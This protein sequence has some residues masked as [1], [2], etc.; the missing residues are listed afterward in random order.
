[1][2][3]KTLRTVALLAISF[4]SVVILLWSN[5][6]LFFIKGV[7]NGGFQRVKSSG[8]LQL[9]N[10]YIID[11][12]EYRIISYKK[13][14][15]LIRDLNEGSL[16]QI[17]G[18]K[19]M[20]RI[21]LNSLFDPSSIAEIAENPFNRSSIDVLESNSRRITS[22]NYGTKKILQY[23]V[24]DSYIDKAVRTSPDEFFV[25][26]ESPETEKLVF[27]KVMFN[28][29]GTQTH[30]DS[31]YFFDALQE[32]G[33]L[34][35]KRNSFFYINYYSNR[36]FNVTDDL[37]EK[38]YHTIDTIKR[39]PRIDSLANNTIIQFSKPP[40]IVNRMSCIDKDFMYV[41]SNINADNDNKLPS[42]DYY[43]IDTYDI[44]NGCSYFET[45]YVRKKNK[46]LLEDFRVAEKKMVLLFQKSATFYRLIDEIAKQKSLSKFEVE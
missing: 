11:R 13:D 24:F 34:L 40:L 39:L 31:R 21:Q 45:F 26:K 18:N 43:I 42:S 27:S 17:T 19:K 9:L 32:D 4:I 1:M 5:P 22:Y 16:I 6:S 41:I 35:N 25:L 15:L 28:K 12:G 36:I 44:K 2:N 33:V 10:D 30:T 37:N 20:E 8:A 3:N 46:E 14:T 23:Y 29:D 7:T 38:Q